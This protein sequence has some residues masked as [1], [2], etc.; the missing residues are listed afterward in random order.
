MDIPLLPVD[1]AVAVADLLLVLGS[2]GLGQPVLHGLD[3]AP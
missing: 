1:L 2:D 3:A